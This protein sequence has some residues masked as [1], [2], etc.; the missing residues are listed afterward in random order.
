MKLNG[1]SRPGIPVFRK[2][3]IRMKCLSLTVAIVLLFAAHAAWGKVI[4]LESL[5]DEMLD[6]DALARLDEPAYVTRQASS[7]QRLSVAPDQEGW[8]ANQDWS[9]FIRKEQKDGRTE[10]VMLDARC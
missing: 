4:T 10:W 8:Y 9:H 7:Y 2:E 5:L 1:K 6:R 3:E